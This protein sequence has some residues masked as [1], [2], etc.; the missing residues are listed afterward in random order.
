MTGWVI[1]EHD[2][3]R[4]AE[5]YE[6]G[7]CNLTAVL[8]EDGFVTL[9]GWMTPTR[10]LRLPA[11]FRPDGTY[12]F[13]TVDDGGRPATV[14]VGPTG[15]VRVEEQFAASHGF[16]IFDNDLVRADALPMVVLSV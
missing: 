7:V 3:E 4:Y 13:D 16:T 10:E 14:V 9:R 12:P 5:R 8:G 2:G 15:L 11:G 6:N 1:T